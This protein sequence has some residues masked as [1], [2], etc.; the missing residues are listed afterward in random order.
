M[1]SL[2]VLLLIF[3]LTALGLFLLVKSRRRRRGRGQFVETF[4]ETNDN[5]AYRSRTT[6]L[7]R[8]T[9]HDINVPPN[10]HPQAITTTS[11]VAYVTAVQSERTVIANPIIEDRNHNLA[12]NAA[13]VNSIVTTSNMAYQVKNGTFE[14]SAGRCHGDVTLPGGAT[15]L[16][17]DQNCTFKIKVNESY[18]TEVATKTKVEGEGLP[19]SSGLE[20]SGTMSSQSGDPSSTKPQSTTHDTMVKPYQVTK[21]PCVEFIDV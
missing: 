17:V 18:C 13:H 12:Q 8:L 7:T 15:Q 5:E 9:R 11:N 4:I 16:E 20:A 2:V 1:I 10:S 6:L 3:A 21:L 14:A 19:G